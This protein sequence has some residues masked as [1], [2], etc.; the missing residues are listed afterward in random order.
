M[1][2]DLRQARTAP[3]GLRADGGDAV[4][5]HDGEGGVARK[6]ACF[7]RNRIM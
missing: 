6:G 5:V 2:K 7:N 4:R 3:E 1:Q